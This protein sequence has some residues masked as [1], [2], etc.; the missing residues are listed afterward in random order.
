MNCWFLN[1]KQWT[2]IRQKYFSK[3]F[4]YHIIMSCHLS[5]LKSKHYDVDYTKPDGLCTF[6]ISYTRTDEI[7]SKHHN[8][9]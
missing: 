8:M 5:H 2:R 3:L 4:A 1:E 7:E 9:L 6:K